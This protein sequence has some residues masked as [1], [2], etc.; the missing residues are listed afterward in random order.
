MAKEYAHARYS[1]WG[2]EDELKAL[3]EGN[4][5]DKSVKNIVSK[6]G[7]IEN[8]ADEA[9]SVLDNLKKNLIK[10]QKNLKGWRNSL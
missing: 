8:R 3:Q 9:I 2:I 1:I 10:F 6:T 4:D 7:E 5:I